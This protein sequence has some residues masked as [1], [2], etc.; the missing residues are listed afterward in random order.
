M[1]ILGKKYEAFWF[2]KENAP[3]RETREGLSDELSASPY[4]FE[5]L[6]AISDRGIN[7]KGRSIATG[8]AFNAFILFSK[9][10][11]MEKVSPISFETV[12]E[13]IPEQVLKIVYQEKGKYRNVYI[14]EKPGETEE[15]EE[16]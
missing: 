8:E 13:K 11:R 1:L 9:I 4:N 2:F 14:Q 5:G 16:T 15:E 12:Q 3:K 6:V 10:L 7:L